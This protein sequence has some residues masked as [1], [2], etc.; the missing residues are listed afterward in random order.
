MSKTEKGARRPQVSFTLDQDE[1]DQAEIYA[2]KRGLSVSQLAKF[3][4]F[5]YM[6]KNTGSKK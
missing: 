6:N 4:F 5:Q 3:A 2:K 1:K